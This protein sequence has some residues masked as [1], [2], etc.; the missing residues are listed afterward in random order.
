MVCDTSWPSSSSAT[1]TLSLQSSLSGRGEPCH[2]L[3]PGSLFMTPRDILL[4]F[5]LTAECVFLY[6]CA[7]RCAY[8]A[9]LTSVSM[10]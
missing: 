2:A 9:I 7:G 3:W 10:F 6:C 8:G 1:Q 5:S 4:L